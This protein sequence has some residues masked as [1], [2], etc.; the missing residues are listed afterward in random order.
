MTNH[1]NS[2]KIKKALEACY[3]VKLQWQ[4]KEAVLVASKEAEPIPQTDA[5]AFTRM[6]ELN[7]AKNA[8]SDLQAAEFEARQ[9]LWAYYKSKKLSNREII[10][11]VA[12]VLQ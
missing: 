8:W 11:I 6:C 3:A 10:N 9:L 1:M 2:P 4:A 5:G 12:T 7:Q